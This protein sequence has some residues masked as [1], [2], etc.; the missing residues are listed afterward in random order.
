MTY[1]QGL[2]ELS[3]PIKYHM[4]TAFWRPSGTT[5]WTAWISYVLGIR[6]CTFLSY[7]AVFIRLIGACFRVSPA[8]SL[9]RLQALCYW[10]KRLSRMC[11]WSRANNTLAHRSP[12]FSFLNASLTQKWLLPTNLFVASS[13]LKGNASMVRNASSLTILV[14]RLEREPHHDRLAR[15]LNRHHHLPHP[16]PAREGAEIMHQEMFAT[17]IGIA[18]NAI[19]D[20]IV[21]SNI[22][23]TPTHSPAKPIPPAK[24]KTKTTPQTQP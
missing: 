21:H 7:L 13:S 17:F 4:L 6:S 11:G 5:T 19:A 15:T 22:K 3:Y 20:S 9:A 23:R 1:E 2:H 10:P 12:P 24:T 8:R 14:Q 18:D 16:G